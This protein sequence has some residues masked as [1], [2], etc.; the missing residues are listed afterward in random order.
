MNAEETKQS[1]G[2]LH[3]DTLYTL[4]Q[5]VEHF[6]LTAEQ[7]RSLRKRLKD[8]AVRMPYRAKSEPWYRWSVVQEVMASLGESDDAMGGQVNV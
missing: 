2:V 5:I 3:S 7:E 8:R 4:S 1:S 6:H